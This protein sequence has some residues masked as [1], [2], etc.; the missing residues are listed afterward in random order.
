MFLYY[1]S[2]SL[3]IASGVLYHL[4]QKLTS[5]NAN[6]AIA[7]IVTYTVSLALCLILLPFY[8]PKDGIV[9]A[10]KQLNWASVALAFAL[11]G[12]EIG[13]L[14]VYRS[15]WNMGIAG[16]FANVASALILIPIGLLL[17]KDK[18]TLM[19]L[20]GVVVCILGLIMVNQK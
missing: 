1:F 2:I 13:F 8:P 19:N 11:V 5:P 4:F 15:G 16:T 12:L 18:I 9:N 17:F 3:A 6:P 20:I 7:L 10:L 14:L